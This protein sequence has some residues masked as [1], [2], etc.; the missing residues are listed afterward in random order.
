LSAVQCGGD[1]RRRL[2][3]CMV[4]QHWQLPCRSVMNSGLGLETPHLKSF[5]AK[6]CVE[7][8][9]NIVSGRQKE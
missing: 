4:G 5:S 6:N 3:A 8:K 2:P 1:G 9:V 7:I